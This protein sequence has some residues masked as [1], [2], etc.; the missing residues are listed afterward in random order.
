MS[1]IRLHNKASAAEN[2][3]LL[4]Q[5]ELQRYS[6]VKNK[7]IGFCFDTTAVDTGLRNGVALRLQEYLGRKVLLLACRHHVLEFCCDA[8][9]RKMFDD[10]IF[11]SKTAFCVLRLNWHKINKN[12]FYLFDISKLP[13]NLQHRCEQVL[14]FCQEFLKNSKNSSLI[15]KDFNEFF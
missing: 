15:R 12:Q 5:E 8:V 9:R 1:I 4:I 13:R 10:S 2:E 6:A 3:A 7:I 14:L 11:L